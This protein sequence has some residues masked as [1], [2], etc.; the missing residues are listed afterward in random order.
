MRTVF[1]IAGLVFASSALAAETVW[2][3]AETPSARFP[4]SETPGPV[5]AEGARLTILVQEGERVRVRSASGYGWIN[6]SAT[7]SEEPASAPMGA[8]PGMMGGAQEFDIEALKK[9]LE[10]K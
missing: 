9:M 6:A 2:A 8:I 4:D 1:F 7:T 10:K 5:F 3:V